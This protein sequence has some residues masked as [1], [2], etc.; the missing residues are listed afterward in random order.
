MKEARKWIGIGT[1]GI[2]VLTLLYIAAAWMFP[3]FRVISRDIAI[4]IL[5][6]FMLIATLLSIA[7]LVAVLSMVYAIYKLTQDEVIPKINATT[8]SV[9]EAL[10]TTQAAARSLRQSADNANTTTVFVAE[11]VASPVIRVSSMVAGVRAAARTLARRDGK[12]KPLPGGL[13]ER[14]QKQTQ[15]REMSDREPVQP[16]HADSRRGEPSSSR[17]LPV[18]DF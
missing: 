3:S 10:A 4:V 11:H 7:L 16:L 5:A 18:S 15:R 13:Q 17:G 8:A 2:L 6:G 12:K 1:G 14:K 9:D